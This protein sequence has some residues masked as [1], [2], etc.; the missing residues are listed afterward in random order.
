MLTDCLHTSKHF[1]CRPSEDRLLGFRPVKPV[2]ENRRDNLARLVK[3][4]GGQVAFANLIGK[5]RNQVGQWLMDPEATGA[6][7]IGNASARQIENA[8]GL[9]SGSLDYPA[10]ATP[11]S[12]LTPAGERNPSSVLASHFQ[13][14]DP[15]ILLEAERWTMIFEAADGAKW[16]PLRRMQRLAD[17]YA[18]IV[19]DG[20]LLSDEHHA[21]YMLEL[22]EAVERR[23]G[24]NKDER[25]EGVH[26]R[27]AAR[28]H[29]S[30]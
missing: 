21:D 8:L 28:K 6:R 24:G 1:A 29:G 14:L 10:D 9:A 4:A 27:S 17:V 16:P 7:N 25:G 2:S 19:A 20:G 12:P 11:G 18:R 13:T 15:A 26:G 3:E 30:K 22:N 5:D 23:T